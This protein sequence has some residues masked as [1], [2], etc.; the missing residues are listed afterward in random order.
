MCKGI[1]NSD[2]PCQ[3]FIDTVVG[4][5]SPAPNGAKTI[6]FLVDTGCTETVISAADAIRLRLSYDGNGQPT[7]NGVPLPRIDDASGVGGTLRVFR[8]DDVYVTLVSHDNK[9][10]ER[11]TEHMKSL[12][13]AEES[14]QDE[15]LLGMDIIRRFRLIVDSELLMVDFTRIPVK[16]TSYFVEHS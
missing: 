3:L 14:Y 5:G 8:L 2:N 7:R 9:G 13:V 15:S 10:N 4:I 12:C 11:H 6:S 1:Y 16:G